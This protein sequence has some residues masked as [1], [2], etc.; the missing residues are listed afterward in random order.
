ML[1]SCSYVG[2]LPF[3]E[4]SPHHF[5]GVLLNDPYHLGSKRENANMNE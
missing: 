5:L 4:V 1:S 3:G 2:W